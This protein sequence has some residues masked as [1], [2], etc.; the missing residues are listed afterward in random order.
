MF[1]TLLQLASLFAV[2]LQQRHNFRDQAVQRDSPFFVQDFF[3]GAIRARNFLL[4][5]NVF[6][7]FLKC[8]F[9]QRFFFRSEFRSQLVGEGLIVFARNQFILAA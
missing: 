1:E 8:V 5:R 4:Q 3:A 7:A 6:G 2:A 9:V